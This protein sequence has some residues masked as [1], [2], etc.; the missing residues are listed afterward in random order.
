VLLITLGSL[1]IA[2]G[3]LICGSVVARALINDPPPPSGF[4]YFDSP[5][6]S[7]ESYS[8][9]P[10]WLPTAIVGS[11]LSAVAAI[12]VRRG[13]GVWAATFGVCNPLTFFLGWLM[14]VF[15]PWH[16]LAP[17]SYQMPLHPL[18]LSFTCLVV[19]VTAFLTRKREHDSPSVRL[20]SKLNC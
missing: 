18:I 4:A 9:R 20:V 15:S 8:T 13:F 5:A 16:G 14:F 12:L 3:F 6:D 10:I 7:A 2:I 17:G 19:L 11:L 1:V